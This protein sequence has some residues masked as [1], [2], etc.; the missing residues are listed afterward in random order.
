M[1]LK[2]SAQ[3]PTALYRTIMH[4]YFAYYYGHSDV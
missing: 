1:I 3:Q 4:Y 2:S